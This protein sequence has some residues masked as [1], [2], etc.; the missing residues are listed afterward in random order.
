[1]GSIKSSA[2]DLAKFLIELGR[3]RLI[4]PALAKELRSPQIAINDS[5]SW[6]LGPCIQ[7]SD[8]GDALWQMGMMP[9]FRS[10]MV[11]YPDHG[12]GVVVLTNSSDGM[13][14]AYDVAARALGGKSEWIGF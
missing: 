7:H 2:S 13:S 10:V 11:I 3:P 6:G 8:Q 9:G 1:V 12:L 4:D 14:V 5:F